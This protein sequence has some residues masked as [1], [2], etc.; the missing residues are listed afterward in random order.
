M[1]EKEPRTDLLVDMRKQAENIARENAVQSPE[2]LEAMSA[3][4][5]RLMIHELLVHQIELQMQNEELH[6][7]QVE[8]EASRAGYRDLYDYAP[9]GYVTING[10]GL[11]LEANHAAASLLGMVRLALCNMPFSQFIHKDEQEIY[12]RFRKYLVETGEPQTYELRMARFDGSSFWV[13]LEATV[14]HDSAGKSLVRVVMSDITERKER[15]TELEIQSRHLAE[16]N[17]AI[18]V[19]IKKMEDD[20]KA[21]E[22][23]I[24][25]SIKNMLCPLLE[26][27]RHDEPSA[28]NRSILSI[29]VTRLE[30]LSS[31]FSKKLKQFNLTNKE[32]QVAALVKEGNTTKEIAAILGVEICSINTH[33]NRIRSKLGLRR[34]VDLCAKLQ[35]L[36]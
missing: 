6:Q 34:T 32:L 9:V 15:T 13:N 4:A 31:P 7:M 33:R 12:Y 24:V 18:N 3:D 35:E 22:E 1:T 21:L 27:L 16:T 11:I 20:K 30:E 17:I 5:I 10:K 8:L 19:L 29:I 23:S 25:S 14:G 26:E 2:N 36:Q 28:R